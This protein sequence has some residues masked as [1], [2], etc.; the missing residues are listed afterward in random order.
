MHLVHTHLKAIPNLSG[1][2]TII[3]GDVSAVRLPYA[4]TGFSR[5][6]AVARVCESSHPFS[7]HL[8]WSLSETVVISS[9]AI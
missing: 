7:S 4:A 8:Q 3:A 6:M 9:V 2:L 1:P 5:Y